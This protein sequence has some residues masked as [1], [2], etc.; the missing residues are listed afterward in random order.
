MK[1]HEE[2]GS[3]AWFRVVLWIVLV[4]FSFGPTFAQAKPAQDDLVFVLSEAADKISLVRFGP[5][6]ILLPR[7]KREGRCEHERTPSICLAALVHREGFLQ[8]RTSRYDPSVI[9]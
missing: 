5:N 2:S 3:F 4:A 9:N 7:L 1:R 6:G 8:L